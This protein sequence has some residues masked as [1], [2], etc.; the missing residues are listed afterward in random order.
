MAGLYI[1]YNLVFIGKDELVGK[2][3]TKNSNTLIL[4][5]NIF[6]AQIFAPTQASAPTQAPAPTSGLPNMCTN[7]DLQKTTRLA[8]ELF[9]K[10]QKYGK[11]N[12]ATQDR[13]LKI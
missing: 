7:V 2:V 8:L 9:F 5:P 4:S 11:T 12:S 3:F 6:Q 1:Y 13:A 10:G